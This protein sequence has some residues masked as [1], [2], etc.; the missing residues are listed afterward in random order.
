[1]NLS[2]AL[3]VYNEEKK[4]ERTLK[5]IFGWAQ[6]IVVVDG[7]SID[8]TKNICQK[9]TDKIF[10]KN[11]E[12]MF[13]KNKNFAIEQCVGNWILFLDADEV[14][15]NDLKREI[16]EAMQ[17]DIFA[18]YDFPRKNFFLGRF[19][20][21]GGQYPDS[22]IRLFKKG[23]G[24]WPCKSV[25]EQ[26]EIKG[27]VGHLKSDLLHYSYEDLSE[28]WR[29]AK[30]YTD[31]TADELKA[32]RKNLAFFFFPYVIWQPLTTFFKI[33]F[34]HKGFIDSW[35]GF[36]FA[37]FSGLHFPIAYFKAVTK[38]NNK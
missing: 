10:Q 20:T 36:L 14:V 24:Y 34:R 35:Q 5:S 16:E 6:E 27:Q 33:Y 28:Y 18:G 31:L 8:K 30:T 37:F 9:Y 38:K 26:M 21:K 32:Q 29:K 13:H 4:I 22:R 17:K 2:V 7:F 23:K 12:L 11:N 3:A 19:L 15:T 25:H 1:M